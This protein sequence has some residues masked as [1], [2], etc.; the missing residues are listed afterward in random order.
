[1]KKTAVLLFL[2]TFSYAVYG[3]RTLNLDSCRA[4]ALKNNKDIW[5][6]QDA[7]TSAQ[8]EHK[9]AQTNY[10]PKVNVEAG[11]L[12][13]QKSVHLLDKDTRSKL[14]SM[15][16]SAGS[17][18][19][20]FAAAIAG[21]YPDLVPLLQSIGTPMV[22]ALN[23]LG[24]GIANAFQTS[25]YNI[26]AGAVGLT[27]PLYFGGRIKAYD[28]ITNFTTE[29]LGAQHDQLQ[30]DVIY[31][32]DQAYWQV[33]SLSEKKQLA[34]SNVKMLQKIDSDI[35]KMYK[36]GLATKASTLTVRVKLNQGE[37]TLTKV[38]DG[39]SL[40]RMLLCQII[41]IPVNS[42][43]TLADEGKTDLDVKISLQLPDTALAYNQRKDLQALSKSISIADQNVKFV[44]GNYLP[45]L[46]LTSGYTLSNPNVYNGFQNKF[47][48]NISVGVTLH[49]PIWNWGEGK[50]RVRAAK[51]LALRQRH[52]YEDAK[53][54]VDLQ[55]NQ[56]KF[57]VDEAQKKL[58][59]ARKDQ[60]K[61]D[62]NLHYADVGFH[63]GVIAA[64]DFLEAQTAWIQA[65]TEKLDAEI[66]V[67]LTEIY[68]SKTLGNISHDF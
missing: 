60:E 55:I 15:G 17:D 6:S 19:S 54:K 20:K 14:T 2:L 25:T 67:K 18:M 27:Q 1:M 7:I 39:L 28:K 61:A 56:A 35:E 42:N 45:S 29:L 66:E 13:N 23:G 49:V 16:T 9:A 57:K 38:S 51:A 62:E 12:W 47:A 31:S 52:Q 44:K 41:G 64:A 59:M 53:E 43:I 50:Y 32:T 48:G 26:W 46:A 40:S 30:Q 24:T 3:Q 58:I 65:R 5:M 22:S 34:E 21:Q 63:E 33:V 8:Y 68:L 4:M 11:Y 37:M 36:E 10:L